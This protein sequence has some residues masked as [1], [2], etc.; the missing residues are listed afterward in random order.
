MRPVTECDTRLRAARI[1]VHK[2]QST[3]SITEC[4]SSL[5]ISHWPIACISIHALHYRVRLVMIDDSSLHPNPFQSTHSITECDRRL[6]PSTTRSARFQSTHSITECDISKP[7]AE[8]VTLI[9]IHALH[10]RVRPTLLRVSDVLNLFQSTHSITECDAQR[11]TKQASHSRF[12]STHSITECDGGSSMATTQLAT[13]QSTH[14]ITECDMLILNS[15][16]GKERYFNPRTPLQSATWGQKSY[17]G[18]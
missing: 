13:F 17:R 15:S 11:R 10:Y 12:Q 9:S 3:H 16:K 8:K 2:F 1:D 18:Q 14:S 6:R 4:D 7:G 5:L